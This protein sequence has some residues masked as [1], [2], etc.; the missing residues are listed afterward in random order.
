MQGTQVP[1]GKL[2]R[3]VGQT[4]HW[5][6]VGSG[7]QLPQGLVLPGP[8]CFLP[9][10]VWGCRPGARVVTQI[11][12]ALET[13]RQGPTARGEGWGLKGPWGCALTGLCLH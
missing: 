5:T 13:E 3:S 9:G 4:E 7:L 6:C 11:P 8:G 12:A 2:R 10:P 1:G